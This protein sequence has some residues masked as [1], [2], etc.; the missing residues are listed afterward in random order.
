[1]ASHIN[2]K[3]TRWLKCDLHLHT[4]ESN[5]FKDQTVTPEQWIQRAIEQGLDCI[6]VTD[7]NSGNAID[8]IKQAALGTGLV[9]FPGVE[10][11]C[12]TSKIHLLI[13]FDVEKDSTYVNDFLIRCG[14][15]RLEFANANAFTSKNIFDVAEIANKEGALIIPAHIDEYNG[16]GDVSVGN[17][18]KFYALDYINAVQVVHKDFLNQSLSTT[19]NTGLIHHLNK[20]YSQPTPSIDDAT[21]KKWYTPVKYAISNKLAI[22]TFSD[23]PHEEG[24]SKH[25]LKGIG[26]RYSWIKMDEKPTLE[27]LRQAILMPKF[28]IRNDFSYQQLPYQEPDL[29]IKSLMVTGSHL[30]HVNHPLHIE[31]NP[32]LTT[33]IG[34]RGSGKSSILRFIRGLFNRTLDI[35]GLSEI[36]SDHNGFYKR[37]DSKTEKGA[38]KDDTEI[39]VEFVRNGILHKITATDIIDSSR[40]TITIEKFDH[41]SW[42]WIPESADGYIDF[43]KYEHYSQKQ[44]YEIAQKPNSLRERIDRSV[45]GL[46]D[47][48]KEREVL[49]LSFLEKS[50]AI[51][52]KKEQITGKGRLQT[53]ITD[54]TNQISLYQQS[55]IA[56]LLTD[57]EKYS[58]QKRLIDDFV[59]EAQK[60]EELLGELAQDTIL[61]DLNFDSFEPS[62]SVE[63]EQL[64]QPMVEGYSAIKLEL[65]ALQEKAAQLRVT[66]ELALRS[67]AWSNNLEKNENDFEAKKEELK[68]DGIDDI[69]KFETLTGSRTSKSDQLD[70]L[71]EIENSLSVDMTER[72]RI[73]TDFFNKTREIFNARKEHVELLMQDD[74]INVTIVPFRDKGDFVTKLREILQKPNGFENDIEYLAD[75][76]FKG[77]TENQMVTVKQTI[78]DSKNGISI[79]GISGYFRKMAGEI[80]ESQMDEIELFWPEDEISIKY[81]PS[82]SSVLKPLSTASAGQKTTAILT[83]IL[84]QG[85]IPLLLD[86]PEDDLDNRLVYELIVDRLN[87]AKEYRQIIVV[88]HNANIPVNGDA[89]YIYSMNSESKT[90]SV[91]HS[92]TVEDRNIKKEICDVMEGTEY[93]FDMR[94]KRYKSII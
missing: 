42:T 81:K 28:R 94:S 86:Q 44:I 52:T 24:D 34:G 83:I 12:D 48:K 19:G 26:S 4:T 88:T 33:I 65:E 57:K 32:Q 8:Q 16:L 36:L 54:L 59:N 70:G 23:N 1:M 22:L 75:I 43:L 31:F 5:C 55:G 66:F 17:L 50:A 73:K 79:N 14:I 15:N 47:L 69:T 41:D 64:T 38:I 63:L 37:Y 89:E 91:L 20:Y 80:S 60:K 93:A 29:W 6:A 18:E 30:T 39:V 58:A 92:G 78:L 61:E 10:I 90:L 84:S 53:E 9:V 49:R 27:S 45:E 35:T 7:H 21:I 25:G 40:Q 51:R 13:L 85:S 76:A 82:G 62:E 56:G 72:D 68:G 11:T 3:G 74:K 71:T 2:F 77:N 67:S 87:Q 46:E